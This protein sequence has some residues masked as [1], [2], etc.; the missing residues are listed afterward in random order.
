MRLVLEHLAIQ[1]HDDLILEGLNWLLML[2]V[3][4]CLTLLFMFW[5]SLRLLTTMPRQRGK[6]FVLEGTLRSD[7]VNLWSTTSFDNFVPLN[8]SS[9]M[10]CELVLT[11]LRM[12]GNTLAR[13]QQRLLPRVL[14]APRQC[15]LPHINR[16]MVVMSTESARGRQS[17]AAIFV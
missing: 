16:L 14:I 4:N 6:T 1:N 3:T 5:F 17:N 7:T 11:D 8:I 9:K 13:P 10:L 2:D 15:V 12:A